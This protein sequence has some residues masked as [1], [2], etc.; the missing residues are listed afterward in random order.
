MPETIESL[1]SR[2]AALRDTRGWT[3][4]QLA[5]RAGI[6]VTFLSEVENNKRKVSA[7]L[8]L[9]IAGSLGTTLDYLMV[10]RTPHELMSRQDETLT[11]PPELAAAADEAGWSYK[12]TVALLQ[13]QQAVVARRTRSGEAVSSKR[14]SK[15]DW[16]S[17][18]QTLI[19]DA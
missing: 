12:D 2:I 3:Q 15:D 1:G 11:I 9:R 14:L 13:G 10:G 4:K 19:Q 8:L 6:S 5:D 17:L 18:H 16:I 7:E